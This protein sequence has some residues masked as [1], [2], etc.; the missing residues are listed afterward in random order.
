MSKLYSGTSEKIEAIRD[1][2]KRSKNGMWIHEIAR[3]T[4]FRSGSVYYFLKTYMV[5][6]VE[7]KR[8]SVRD[9]VKQQKASYIALVKLKR[10]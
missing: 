9:N 4:G 2:L 7:I 5:D 3:Q 8:I 1:V 10:V 6:E